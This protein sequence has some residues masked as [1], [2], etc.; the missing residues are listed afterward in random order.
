ML[1]KIKDIGKISL[2]Q[3]GGSDPDKLM[4]EIV[5]YQ[6]QDY[7]YIHMTE[8]EAKLV[9]DAMIAWLDSLAKAREE[10]NSAEFKQGDQIVYSSH[11]GTEGEEGF[12]SS[13][14]KTSKDAVFCR[15]FRKDTNYLRT[16]TCSEKVPI[17]NLTKK[18]SRPQEI[19][20]KLIKKIKREGLCQGLN[21]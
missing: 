15:F 10:E 21:G 12:V 7:K 11:K 18:D 14:S 20:D 6:N 4:L 3:F 16:S 19:I 5:Q 2:N 1:K 8:D 17:A 9:S 13:L